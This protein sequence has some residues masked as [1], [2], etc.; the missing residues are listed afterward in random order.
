MD[1]SGS[2]LLQEPGHKFGSVPGAEFFKQEI[3]EADFLFKEL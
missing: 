1:A 2:S 3:R